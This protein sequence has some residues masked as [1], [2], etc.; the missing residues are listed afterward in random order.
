VTD[1]SQRLKLI[2]IRQGIRQT[3]GS[4]RQVCSDLR[5][6]TIDHHGLSAAVR[7]FA[8]QWSEQ[9]GI[10]VAL[11]IDPSLGRLPEPIELS[12]FRIAQEGLRNVGK[13]AD[14]SR[15]DLTMKRTHAASL[16]LRLTDNGRG[17][18]AP[19]NL[20]ELA[21]QKHFGL[22]GISERVSL[23]DGTLEI[24]SP[25]GGGMTLQIEIPIPYPAISD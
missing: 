11:E 14:A 23:F 22:V 8:S 24:T 25:P 21:E 1:E 10:P 12:V 6:P 17:T 9:T 15:V 2:Q 16:L 3:V 20:A 18:R 13:H 4:L 7:S 5:P 19:V